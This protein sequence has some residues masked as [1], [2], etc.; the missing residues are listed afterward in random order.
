MADSFGL[1]CNRLLGQYNDNMKRLV[2][3]STEMIF[4]LVL[5]TPNLQI[6]RT[7]SNEIRVGKFYI[8]QYN[9]NGNKIWCPILVIDDR[10]NAELQ[11]RII[12]AINF[13]YLPYR[14]KIV[15][16]DKLF[17]MF[18]SIIDK[19]KLNNDNG[20]SVNEEI[21]LKINF[22]SIYKT[23]QSN[24]GFNYAITAYD[25]TKI[26]GMDSGTG[27]IYGISTT[28]L[29]RFIFIDTKIINKRVMMDLLKETDVEKEK[30]KLLNLLTAYE[31]TAVDY[32][33]DVKEYYEQLKLLEGHY[34]LYEN[35]K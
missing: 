28:I 8:I 25:Y 9:Y 4:N 14:Y 30:I 7:P 11:K 12:Y 13:D 3:E 1:Y 35:I 15:Y 22:E 10:Y 34:K 29:S 33:N 23:L 32:E 31:K 19:N 6:R 16:L 17:K 18:S 2:E 24:G 21:P 20:N 27:E 26:V 5:K